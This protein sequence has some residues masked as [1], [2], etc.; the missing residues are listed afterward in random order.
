VLARAARRA[1]PQAALVGGWLVLRFD[2]LAPSALREIHEPSLGPHV[3]RNAWENLVGVFGGPQGLALAALGCAALA[4]ALA[5]GGRAG[6]PL[7]AALRTSLGCLAWLAIASAPF[8]LLPFPQL[9]YGMLLEAPA[10]LLVAAWLDAGWRGLGTRHPRAAELAL[11]ALCVAAIPFAALAERARDLQGVPARRLVEA[12]DAL[13]GLREGARVVVLYGAPGL[14]D[15]E[16][17][18]RLRYLAYNGTVFP[19]VHPE[20]ETSVRFHDLAERAPRGAVRP[21]ARYLALLPGL[22]LAPADA[23]LLRR[24]LPRG[25]DAA[26]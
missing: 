10:S 26:R 20:S 15:A 8:A 19:A 11:V 16:S 7:R 1:L 25:S 21:G 13:P 4:A 6:L 23:S 14:A 22:V 17:A 24:E 9:R 18:L 5:R 2:L 3:A 12:V